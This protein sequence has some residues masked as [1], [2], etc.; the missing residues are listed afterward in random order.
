MF[1]HIDFCIIFTTAY[2]KFASKAFRISAVDFLLKP[3]DAADFKVAVGKAEEKISS[4][5]EH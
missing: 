2:D 3:I 1:D 5:V 4:S